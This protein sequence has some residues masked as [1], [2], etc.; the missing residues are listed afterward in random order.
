[1]SEPATDAG[2][3]FGRID[4]DGTV[5][6]RTSAGERVIG[7]WQAG[8]PEEGIAYYSRRYEDLAAEV[9]VLQAR[10]STASADPKTVRAA[11]S[12]LRAALPEAHALGDL[13]ALDA[14]LAGVLDTCQRR[15]AEQAEHKAAAAAAAADRKRALV[16]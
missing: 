10:S 7:S 11:A 5:Y 1:M 2:S 9:S 15:L 14:R 4:A 16:D 3:A 13:D 12:K 6:V 8:T